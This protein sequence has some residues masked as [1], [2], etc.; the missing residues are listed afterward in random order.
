MHRIRDCGSRWLKEGEAEME[1][2][3]GIFSAKNLLLLPVLMVIQVSFLKLHV[4]VLYIL[5]RVPNLK[6]SKLRECERHI[7]KMSVTQTAASQ[8]L[9]SCRQR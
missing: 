3:K 4:Y 1:R 6:F 8:I 2:V 9:L 7:A 5:V